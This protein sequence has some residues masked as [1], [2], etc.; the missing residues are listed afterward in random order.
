MSCG[1]AS[2]KRTTATCGRRNSSTASTPRT[3]ADRSAGST[4][5]ISPKN[6]P[7]PSVRERARAIAGV[8]RDAARQD[9]EQGIAERALADDLFVCRV[10]LELAELRQASELLALEAT[11]EGVQGEQLRSE[12]HH[13]GHLS[14]SADSPPRI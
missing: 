7:G 4:S 5:D 11:E 1:S 8:D 2:N 3:V 14:R 6:S 9:Q 13:G 10:A 12:T